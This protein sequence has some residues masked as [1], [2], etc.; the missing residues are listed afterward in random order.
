MD[1]EKFELCIDA[2]TIIGQREYQVQAIG[3]VE[4]VCQQFIIPEVVLLDKV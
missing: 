2:T 4:E 3:H 1:P